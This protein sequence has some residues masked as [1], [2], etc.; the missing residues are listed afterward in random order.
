MLS[1][2]T[3]KNAGDAA[4]YYSS[5]DN[6]YT[7]EEGIE[8]S[9]WVGRGADKLQ[10]H[11]EVNPEKFTAL[12]KGQ[13]PNGE[14]VGTV[15]DGE[16]KH[17]AGWDLTFSAPKSVSVMALIGGD[18]R[19]VDAHR[20]AVKVALSEVERS[21][22]EARV[23]TGGKL[24]YHNTNNMVA[25]LYHHDLSREQDPQLHTH[26]VVMNMTERQ[27]GKWR[28]QA[29]KIGR[30]DKET[31]SEVHGFIERVRNNKRYFGKLYEAELAYQVKELG[32]DVEVNP[33]TGVFEIVGVNKEVLQFFS[34]R[35]EKIKQSLDEHGLSG[36]RAADVAAQNTREKKKEV[37][38][39]LLAQQWKQEALERG[40]HCSELIEKSQVTL[41]SPNHEKNIVKSKDVNATAFRALRQAGDSLS[42]F[43]TI[44]LLEDVIMAASNQS[45]REKINVESLLQ[46]A[47][48]AVQMGEFISIAENQGKTWF[49]TKATLN[50]EKRITACLSQATA[51]KQKMDAKLISH[52]SHQHEITPEVQ[53]ALTTIFSDQRYVLV[54]GNKASN[55]LPTCIA[56]IAKS[57]GLE[58]AIVSPNQITSKQLAERIKPQ[59]QTLWE[60]VKSLFV[61]TKIRNEGV[62]Q[63]LTNKENFTT[64]DILLVDNSHLLSAKQTADLL[65]WGKDKNTQTIFLSQKNVLLS[66]KTGVSTEYLIQN[67]IKTVSL[68]EVQNS[69]GHAVSEKDMDAVAK[70]MVDDI[71]II[72]NPEDRQQAMAKQFARLPNFTDAFL[73]ANNKNAVENLNQLVHS[74]LKD[75][76]KL[77]KG[78]PSSV[79]L[80]QFLSEHTAKQATAYSP[81]FIV[82]FNEDYKSLAIKRSEY[83]S[84][85]RHD[86]KS[87]EVIL[88]NSDGKEIRWQP[89]KIAG[90]PGKVELFKEQARELCVGERIVFYRGLKYS[91]VTKGEYFTVDAIR[92]NKVK[93]SREQG[94][95]VE[96][97]LTKSH[98]RHFDYGYAAT[99]H[100]IA[101]EKPSHIIAEL[102]VKSF[103][104]DQRRL[105]QMVSQS[106][107]VSIYTDNS[108]SLIA[109]LE[110]KTGNRLTAHETF[111]RSEEIKQNLHDFYDVLEKA[112][113]NG[114]SLKDTQLSKVAIDA[115]NYSM[116]HLAEREAGFTHKELM[117]TAM[118]Y[119][120]GKVNPKA[121]TDATIAMEKIGMI[122]R[123]I[124]ADDT[125]WTT[126]EAV[127]TER[128]ILAFSTQDQGKLQPIASDEVVLRYCDPAKLHPEQISAIKT[129]VQSTDRVLSIQGRAGTGK[130]TLMAT[131]DQVLSAKDLLLGE[132]YTLQG[133]AP[134][135]KAIK[136]L[137]VH[138]IPARTIDRFLLDI[139]QLQE[140]KVP[141]DFSKTVLVVDEASMVSNHKMLEILKIAHDCNFREVIP[142]GDTPQLAA[143]EAGKPHALIQQILDPILLEDIR[144]Q[145]NPILKE[146]VQAIYGGDVEKTFSILKDS[147]IEI[148][149]EKP[150]DA[151]Q[152]RIVALVSDYLTL[153]SQGEDV[154][155]IAPS[156]ADRKAINEQVRFQLEQQ[157]ILTGSGHAF[158]VLS[159]K[160][161]T[162]VE[163]SEV[164]NFEPDQIIRFTVSSG[165]TIKAGDYFV[166]K[167][168]DRPHNLLV[169]NKMDGKGDDVIWQVPKSHK[170]INNSIEVFKKEERD[171]KVGDKIVWVRTNQKEGVLAADFA[172]VTRIDDEMIT[173][174]SADNGLFT[175]N[176]KEEKHQH[177]DHAYAITAYGA[178]GG[179]YSTVLALFESYR[180]KLMNLKTFLVTLTRP[181]NELRIY[182][183]D[184]DQLKTCISNNPAD[185]SSSLE[186]IG[187]YPS[188]SKK[189]PINKEIKP[190]I[191]RIN[192]P[193]HVKSQQYDIKQVI[194]GLSQD[195]ERIAIDLL[196]KPKTRTANYLQFGSHNGSLRVTINGTKQGLWNDFSGEITVNGKT[197]GNML[198]FIEVFGNM[199]KK[200]AIQY[201]AR[202]LGMDVNDDINTLQRSENPKI[203]SKKDLKLQQQAELKLQQ[204]K[205]N[206]AKKLA[207]ESEP[208]KGT[209]VEKYLKEHRGVEMQTY[210][211]DVRYHPGIYSKI[212]D[213]TSPAM[214]VIARDKKGNIQAVQATYL[215]KETAAKID[216]STV[217][218]QKQT[219]G[220][221]SGATVNINSNG[222]DRTLIAEGTETG[223]SLAKALPKFN[224]K[225]T[226]GKAN[227]L[228]LDPQGISENI[229]L[230]LDNDGKNSKEDKLISD[231]G[232]RLNESGKAVKIAMPTAFSKK[233]DY[234][235]IIKEKGVDSI[236]N[237][238]KNAISYAEFY[239]IKPEN[240]Q[241]NTP[242]SLLSSEKIQS[243]ANTLSKDSI[244]NDKLHLHA[245]RSITQG[246][247][248]KTINKSIEKQV[249]IEREI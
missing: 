46:A 35:S 136:E 117:L 47:D 94:K 196:G 146:A 65:E 200:E 124:R 220:V 143:I 192:Q 33:K 141:H 240:S 14:Q 11:G 128:K 66:Q 30:Y 210:P 51:L 67:G 59:S 127:N 69:I 175:F 10:L 87:N 206:F 52:Y 90:K 123:G 239:G 236:K 190:D 137:R 88:K 6:Y 219:F 233:H 76:G 120:L 246:D 95:S 194:A 165:R 131:L 110:K 126:L 243:F 152:K 4:H 61:D 112:I 58:M 203:T 96:L 119:A 12:L 213:K 172:E 121:F 133:I 193:N 21:C 37:D 167:S 162:R 99:S 160:D 111:N 75:I 56:Q 177:W 211:E 135:H 114:S 122:E 241:T 17:R 176:G 199:G 8:Q 48:Y 63:F 64:P 38:R 78:M 228:H 13:L 132:G 19:L 42:E 159:S 22:S 153:K 164:V 26:T 54:E 1:T 197:G 198:K 23:K 207:G 238:I 89:D 73:I 237:D 92:H 134:T 41:S 173:V 227:L 103:H 169:L 34:K 144:R 157:G 60:H 100:A 93:L 81:G 82:R 212:N 45:I 208:L 216:K 86:K 49:M 155:I 85:I 18:K 235:D 80:P 25:A 139:R 230:C 142:T 217:K 223:L 101:H 138:G 72:A 71:Q 83:L 27:D 62:M 97:D 174:K 115:V 234:N 36:S 189:P 28:S 171:L 158:S 215:D 2:S 55:E 29:S 31:S 150:E 247:T 98:N 7:R 168:I 154:Q 221:L 183:D 185:K 205:I 57:A 109:T 118:Q 145:K 163:R 231:A 40:L 44:F 222:G 107:N 105:F 43:N 84:I 182:T 50:D 147:I 245:Y 79:L 15:I 140:N 151:Y 229:I 149:E 178:Q 214:L 74:E 224:V 104:T 161:M 5:T 195:A 184:K 226:L 186:V 24:S 129:I 113:A 187:E 148:N 70:K 244:E 218:I 232:R 125:L 108:R 248:Q 77:G 202:R 242:N 166:I 179:T 188:A 180:A 249:Q 225:V 32:Y 16:I 130:T 39:E 209:I 3:I 9:E 201:A 191:V 181:I 204:N 53:V 102:P 91:D 106:E 68:S 20:Q 156:H 170:R 116:Q